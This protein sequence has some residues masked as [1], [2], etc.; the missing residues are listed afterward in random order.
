[1]RSLRSLFHGAIKSKALQPF[2]FLLPSRIVAACSKMAQSFISKAPSVKST[3]P[4]S[5][6]TQQNE[7]DK[8]LNLKKLSI[9]SDKHKKD[10]DYAARRPRKRPDRKEREAN[11]ARSDKVIHA[12]RQSLRNNN[13]GSQIRQV[14]SSPRVPKISAQ[15]ILNPSFGSKSANPAMDRSQRLATPPPTLVEPQAA[16]IFSN[17]ISS[18]PAISSST[19]TSEAQPLQS[20]QPRKLD[21]NAPEPH[22]IYLSIASLVPMRLSV[23]QRL[24][25]V[26]D[27]NGTLLFRER[28]SQT[29][30]PRPF[31]M[32]FLDYCL[33]NH[34]ILIWSSAMPRNVEAVCKKLFTPEQHQKL[35]GVWARDTLGLTPEQYGHKTQVYKHLDRIW[36]NPTLAFRHPWL[37][38]SGVMWSQKNTLLVDDSIEKA[39]AQPYNHIK[40]SEFVK[41]SNEATVQKGKDVLG[42]VTAYL[43]D[44]RKW[45]NVSAFVRQT[46]FEVNRH[47]SWDWGEEKDDLRNE[48]RVTR[49]DREKAINNAVENAMGA[50]SSGGI[51][52]EQ[53]E[54]EEEAVQLSS[55]EEDGGVKLTTD[56]GVKLET[57]G[58]VKL[59]IDYR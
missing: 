20:L 49:R 32:N 26:L 56:E 34:V 18:S 22:A 8:V 46:R 55:D 3:M 25:V 52:K 39:R 2:H 31:L 35:F 50:R 33:E 10:S 13:P 38:Q 47:W 59:P 28:G 44:A 16:L 42:Q 51:E 4:T 27:L 40:I 12:G 9:Q 23:P 24:L 30:K 19:L 45:D 53:E 5:G 11:R 21:R 36:A 41:N 1:M 37:Q 14:L 29:Y 57:D 7:T 48:E 43:E 15:P 6:P 58:G 54:E 17:S